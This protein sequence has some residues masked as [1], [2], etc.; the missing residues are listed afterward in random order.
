MNT[1]PVAN[2]A[3]TQSRSPRHAGPNLGI[4]AIVFTAL[5]LGSLVPVSAFGF[6]FGVRP[7]YFPAP[8]APA[9]DIVSYFVTHPE[10]V[11]LCAFLQ[12]GSAIPI[13][14]FTATVVSRLRFLGVTAAGATIAL[15]GGVMLAFDSAASASVLWTMA[16]AGI[17]QDATLVHAL[18]FLQYAL[19][20]PGFAIPIGL[21]MAGVSITAGF[22]RLLPKWIVALGI[23]LAVIGELTWFA[24]LTQKVGF[25]IPLTRFPAFVW[26]IAAGFALPATLR[27]APDPLRTV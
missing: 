15:F 18:Y 9:A 5:K 3:R 24:L 1:A 26:L 20:G 6:A 11:L 4:L 12:F 22:T 25:L 14:L 2:P 21:L 17:T 16:H 23:A 10:A 19:G 27:R 8:S 7:P 13:G